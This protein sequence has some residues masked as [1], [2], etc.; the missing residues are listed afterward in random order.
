MRTKSVVMCLLGL[1]LLFASSS[2]AAETRTWT[3]K[4]G[5][6]FDAEFVKVEH[7]GKRMPVTFR[8]PDGT[9]MTVGFAG[10][11]EEDRKHVSRQ[12]NSQNGEKLEPSA[13]FLA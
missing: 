6:T 4:D 7:A 8:K 2:S 1:L 5:T 3:K 10:L 9:E 13:V 11:S 12:S